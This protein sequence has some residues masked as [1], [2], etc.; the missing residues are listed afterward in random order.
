MLCKEN[1][2]KEWRDFLSITEPIQ[3]QGKVKLNYNTDQIVW[4]VGKM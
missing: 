4:T 2:K 3:M 1:R